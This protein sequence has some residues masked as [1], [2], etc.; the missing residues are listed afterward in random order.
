MYLLSHMPG[1]VLVDNINPGSFPQYASLAQGGLM[2]FL[3]SQTAGWNHAMEFGVNEELITIGTGTTTTGANTSLLP[4][5]SLIEMVVGRVT[6]A[7][8][9]AAT[10]TVGDTAQPARFVSG[11]AVALGTTFVGTLH[12]NPAVASDALGP[13]QVANAALVI[14]P[15]ANPANNAGR[16][17]AQVAFKR[18]SPPSLNA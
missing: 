14:D 6:V 3:G 5:N 9:T 1:W 15:N 4:A 7:I 17:R 16:I 11:V 10:F 12:K 2:P 8:P 18:G 13:R